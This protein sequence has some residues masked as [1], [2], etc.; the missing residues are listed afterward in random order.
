MPYIFSASSRASRASTGSDSVGS[1]GS[2]DLPGGF[3]GQS[4]VSDASYAERISAVDDYN[5]SPLSEQLEPIAVIGMG[6][7]NG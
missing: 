1:N 2:I 4:M 3:L 7:Y 5:E 6:T